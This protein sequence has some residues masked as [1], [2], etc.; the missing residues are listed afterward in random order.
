MSEPKIVAPPTPAAVN[1][2]ISIENTS[3]YIIRLSS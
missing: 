1:N 3:V 2:T